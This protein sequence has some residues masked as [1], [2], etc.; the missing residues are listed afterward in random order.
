MKLHRFILT[1]PLALRMSTDDKDF[2]H[3]LRT[4]FRMKAGD[5]LILCD[6][7]GYEANAEIDTITKDRAVFTLT[8]PMR[9]IPNPKVAVTLYCALARGS[10]FDLIA[11]KVVEVGVTKLVPLLTE[12]TVKTG[13]REDRIHTIMKEAAEQ[14]GRGRLPELSEPVSFPDAYRQ[15]ALYGSRIGLV[16]GSTLFTMPGID[17]PTDVSIFVG[18][19]GGFTEGEVALFDHSVS[20]GSEVLR[21]ETAAIIG[22]YLAA[23]GLLG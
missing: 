20:L 2:L 23:H 14:S 22:T 11:E 18:P 9:A 3:Q 19:E 4:V 7:Q 17:A 12:R 8:Y 15:A 10:H 1:K 16:P 21:V 6:G 13:F 5:E